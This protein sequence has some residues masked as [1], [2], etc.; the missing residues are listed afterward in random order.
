MKENTIQILFVI[1][2]LITLM[3]GADLILRPHQQKFLQSKLE[4]I[5]LW[6]DYTNLFK[7]FLQNFRSFFIQV[8]GLLALIIVVSSLHT[9]AVEILK[10]LFIIEPLLFISTF[11]LSIFLNY[12]FKPIAKESYEYLRGKSFESTVRDYSLLDYFKRSI[13]VLFRFS[14]ALLVMLIIYC[15]G[16][17]LFDKFYLHSDIPIIPFGLFSILPIAI[18]FI[19]ILV[20][21]FLILIITLFVIL[22]HIILKVFKSILWR[23]VEYNKGAFAAINLIITVSLGILAFLMES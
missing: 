1:S 20:T 10:E 15:V 11:G 4:T 18:D 12:R 19:S 14:I 21:L 6:F 5:T 23:I 16:T 13:I 7:W 3:K 22:L 17:F 9:P 2:F 8:I